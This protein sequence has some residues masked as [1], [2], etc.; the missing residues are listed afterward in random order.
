MCD[1]MD[2][3][4]ATLVYSYI[5]GRK[6]VDR[7]IYCE[8]LERESVRLTWLVRFRPKLVLDTELNIVSG[9]DS[10]AMGF[11]LGYFD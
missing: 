5:N 11:W 9:L 2:W 10:F 7:L 8:P 4:C 6:F 3:K 1:F